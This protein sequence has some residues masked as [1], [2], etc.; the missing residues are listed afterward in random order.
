MGLYTLVTSIFLMLNASL[1]FLK[2]LYP[3]DDWSHSFGCFEWF[4][5]DSPSSSFLTSVGGRSQPEPN[6]LRGRVADLSKPFLKR[7]LW[8]I[9]VVSTG[10][11]LCNKNLFPFS[12]KSGLTCQKFL[13]KAISSILNNSSWIKSNYFFDTMC[14]LRYI[15]TLTEQLFILTKAALKWNCK[16]F[17]IQH[18]VSVKYIKVLQP[19]CSSKWHSVIDTNLH[20]LWLGILNILV[21]VDWRIILHTLV[22]VHWQTMGE[23]WN[24]A[25][26]WN[27]NVKKINLL[28]FT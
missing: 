14:R 5:I 16:P 8:T 11:V 24:L 25:L 19:C 21:L 28:L 10:A 9:N 3:W 20:S 23:D 17:T 22:L 27:V 6:L 13:A 1:K 2:N 15:C 18:I 7:N 26:F 4:E 12:Q